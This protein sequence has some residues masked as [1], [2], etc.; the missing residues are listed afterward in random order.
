MITIRSLKHIGIGKSCLIIGGGKSAQDFDYN[1]LPEGMVTFCIN[2]AFPSNYK[3]DYMIYNDITVAKRIK[4]GWLTVDKDI[5]IISFQNSAVQN[6]KYFYT[7]NDFARERVIINESDNTGLKALVMCKKIFMF[8]NIY[9]IGFDF[10]SFIKDGKKYSH[11][12]G[13]EI[14]ED[15]KYTDPSQYGSHLKR[16]PEMAKQFNKIK[17]ING[18]YNCNQE[19]FLKLFPFALPY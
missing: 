8:D 16:L 3:V 6:T 17:E 11:F 9:L 14:G 10:T 12:Y 15:K 4:R 2:E 7:L 13:D 5:Q 18:I 19:S 1:K